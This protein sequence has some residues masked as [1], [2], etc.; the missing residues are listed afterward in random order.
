MNGRIVSRV[1]A[2]VALLLGW[3]AVVGTTPAHAVPVTLDMSAAPPAPWLLDADPAAKNTFSGGILT[4]TSP[5][6]DQYLLTDRSSSWAQTV[7]NDFGWT[8]R[9]RLRIDA[10]TQGDCG[11]RPVQLEADD[12]VIQVILGWSTT[13]VCL[14]DAGNPPIR[15]PLDTTVF[16]TYQVK[17]EGAQINVAVDGTAVIQTW[18]FSSDTGQPSLTFGDGDGNAGTSTKVQWDEL[19]YD[20]TLGCTII[21]TSGNDT[22]GGTS[23]DDV[24][25]GLGGTDYIDGHQGN[26]TI[27]GGTGNDTLRGALGD[28]HLLGGPGAD[29]LI[30]SGGNDTMEGGTGDDSFRAENVADGADVMIGGWGF[31]TVNYSARTTPVRVTLD[32][33][34]DDGVPGSEHDNARPDI[35]R[36]IGGSANDTMSGDQPQQTTLLGGA[37]DDVLDVR[38][39]DGQ[40]TDKIDGGTGNDTCLA[41]PGATL[42]SCP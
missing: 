9:T 1:A 27:Y 42:I 16:H 36:A 32:W 35:E 3:V 21:G 28:D 41:D 26:D 25:C 40:P 30:G 37:G 39:A 5:G 7:D 12:G 13:E 33:S 4:M 8:L 14:Y 10:S 19:T 24:I 2:A 34:Y 38:D 17:V 23:G 29:T 11:R 20:T 15:V 18:A 22:I 31:D 6:Y